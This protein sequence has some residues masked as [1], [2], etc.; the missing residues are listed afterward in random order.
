MI[1]TKWNIKPY[2]AGRKLLRSQKNNDIKFTNMQSASIPKGTIAKIYFHLL[3]LLS[4]QIKVKLVEFYG[5]F[6]L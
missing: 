4:S 1:P 3:Q 5:L 6:R 2:T